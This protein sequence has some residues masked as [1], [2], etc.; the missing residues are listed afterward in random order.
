MK[1]II[2]VL[3]SIVI[4]S[5]KSQT[6][7]SKDVI[8]VLI[9]G[10]SLT[11]YHNMPQTLQ[12][13]LKETDPHINIEQ[14]TFPG[15]PLSGHLNQIITSSSE[16]EVSTRLKMTGEKTETEKKIEEKKWDIIILQT[17]T[18]SVLIPENRRYKINNA[19]SDI[20]RLVNNPKCKFIL[21]NT[22]AS[23][24]EY[25]KE[26]CYPCTLIDESIESAKCCS[27]V[28]NNLRQE[29]SVINEA[30][31]KLATDN[32]LIR[33]DNGTKFFETQL[34]HPEIELYDDNSHPSKFGS[35]LNA[36]IF[37]QMLTDKKASALNYNGEIEPEKSKL[38]K[39]MAD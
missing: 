1:K 20:R 12:E 38:L 29:V 26:Y 19:I 8:N 39:D 31:E 10:N 27:P 15:M 6:K 28:I 9:V 25:P 33:S 18:I 32:N 30:Y 4:F 3:I 11:Y 14:S 36:C 17:G 2:L 16:S 34:K 37:Y 22:W 23:K 13:I 24:D 21:F 7:I 5:C 35:F